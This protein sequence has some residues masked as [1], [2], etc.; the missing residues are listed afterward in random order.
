M[1]QRT[2]PAGAP[3]RRA[4]SW[5]EAISLVWVAISFFTRSSS[6]RLFWRR[7][8]TSLHCGCPAQAVNSA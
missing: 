6:A 3:A 8:E 1:G 2:Q 5:M 7:A 4:S